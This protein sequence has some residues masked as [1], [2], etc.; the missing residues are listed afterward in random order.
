MINKHIEKLLL[1]DENSILIKSED[2]A[3]VRTENSL[4]HAM[5][6]LTNVGYS[7]IPVLDKDHKLQGIITLPCIIDGI[8]NQ[9]SYD[10][11]QLSEKKVEEVIRHQKNDYSIVEDKADLED[12]LRYLVDHNYVCIVDKDN[13]FQG[14]ITRK[15]ILKRFNHMLHELNN[16]YDLIKKQKESA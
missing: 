15:T 3:T 5:M 4:L 7:S 10:F 2:V 1:C 9:I 12:I 11:D 14:I 8:K 13:V 16:Q 6:I